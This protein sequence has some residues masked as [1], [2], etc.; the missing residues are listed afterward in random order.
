[1]YLQFFYFNYFITK[2]EIVLNLKKIYYK[3]RLSI[4]FF[5]P[6]LKYF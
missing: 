4:I 2:N 5:E 1:M 6:H 3:R